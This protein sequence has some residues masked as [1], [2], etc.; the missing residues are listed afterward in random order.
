MPATWCARRWI[1]GSA[2]TALIMKIS[3]FVDTSKM[4]PEELARRKQAGFNWICYSEEVRSANPK[5]II[6]VQVTSREKSGKT[7]TPAE[8]MEAIKSV[9]E[10]V[11]GIWIH[12]DRDGL[13]FATELVTLM[14]KAG[15]R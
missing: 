3:K 8:L 13:E 12:N 6:F 14:G 1:W 10:F 15:Y 5:A 11:D 7:S 2:P 9:A 4:T